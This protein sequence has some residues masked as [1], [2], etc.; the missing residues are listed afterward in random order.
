MDQQQ[1]DA[2]DGYRFFLNDAARRLRTVSRLLTELSV[3][4]SF[5]AIAAV[6]TPCSLSAIN[7][8]SSVGAHLRDDFC[9]NAQ[10]RAGE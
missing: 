4:P 2:A 9:I 6:P 5:L 1:S 8:S 7:R 10:R 3:R